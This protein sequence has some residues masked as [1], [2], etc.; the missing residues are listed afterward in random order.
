MTTSPPSVSAASRKG[1]CSSAER[2]SPA[3]RSCATAR[4]SWWASSRRS[5]GHEWL[6]AQPYCSKPE[7]LNPGDC[8]TNEGVWN[9]GVGF[10]HY[11]A[12]GASCL[13]PQ[14][15]FSRGYLDCRSPGQ[16]QTGPQPMPNLMQEV[17]GLAYLAPRETGGFELRLVSEPTE[18][19]ERYWAIE[20]ENGPELYY[21]VYQ[22]GQ[23]NLRLAT[24]V[25]AGD[26]Q[27]EVARRLLL[28]DYE[29]YNLQRDPADPS[30]VMFDAL[31]FATNEYLFGSADTTLPTPE[32][33]L[34]SVQA[35]QGVS[36]RVET[37]IVLPNF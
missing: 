12:A 16:A 22:S 18:E 9:N 26:G 21:S 27:V 15:G 32:E 23:Y 28:E 34:A 24:Q 10:R 4:S 5:A 35:V 13:T 2:A 25:D 36:G 17:N 3:S 29:V 6:H 30:R 20:G 14:T 1:S 7:Y 19:V 8:A 31:Q 37:L 33:V 11:D